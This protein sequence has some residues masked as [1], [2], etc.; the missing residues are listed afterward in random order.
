MQVVS[1]AYVQLLPLQEQRLALIAL[2]GCE[3]LDYV[4]VSVPK[5]MQ[6]QQDNTSIL[7]S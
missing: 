6:A 4:S 5:L 7:F 3:F 2:N 1:W